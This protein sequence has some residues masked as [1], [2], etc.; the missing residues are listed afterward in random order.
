MMMYIN[1]NPNWGFFMYKYNLH[2]CL[3]NSKLRLLLN[4]ISILDWHKRAVVGRGHNAKRE[5]IKNSF[6]KR[7]FLPVWCL[8]HSFIHLNICNESIW[9]AS[10]IIRVSFSRM[11]QGWTWIR[12]RKAKTNSGYSIDCLLSSLLM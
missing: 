11:N 5:V 2:Q 6:W 1:L 8:H 4:Y 3:F 9:G 7:L 12:A 10:P